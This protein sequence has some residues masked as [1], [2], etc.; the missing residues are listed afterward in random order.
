MRLT[1]LALVL[2]ASL[3]TPIATAQT[4]APL[5]GI[6]INA[7]AGLAGFGLD[8]S[9]PINEYTKVRAGYST[10]THSRSYTQDDLTFD[11]DLRLGG[12]NLLGDL[13]PWKNGFRVTGGLY[14]PSHKL[15]G[16][17]KYNGPTRSI[18]L[19]GHTYT[20][21]QV[22]NVDV[23]AKWSGVRP[24]L[25]VGYDTLQTQQKPGVFFTTDVGVIF[26]GKPKLNLN[27]RYIDPLLRNQIAS[28][29][30]A[31]KR[32]IQQDLNDIKALPVI[33]VGVGYRF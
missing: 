14:G 4:P 27:A 20:S 18:T 2:I 33:Q 31:E 13:H 24:Y 25:G 12:W 28:D 22:G 11:A 5:Q 29:I 32:S 10:F 8:V 21:D 16:T 26:S 7:K 17:G 19:N 6:G 23:S 9:K 1:P 15:S 30:E 3:A